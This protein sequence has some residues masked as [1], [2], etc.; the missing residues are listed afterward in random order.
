MR[1]S[2]DF[3]PTTTENAIKADS[4]KRTKPKI[5]ISLGRHSGPPGSIFGYAAC[6]RVLVLWIPMAILAVAWPWLEPLVSAQVITP[7]TGLHYYVLEN[8]NTGQVIQ[9]GKTGSAGGAFD[10]LFLGANTHYRIRVLQ[11]ANLLTGEI[12]FTTPE[13][14][15]RFKLPEIRVGTDLS[16]DSDGDGLSDYA[17]FVVGTDPHNPD[18]DGDGIS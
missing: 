16:P 6:R 8:L 10:R 7:S 4:M 2:S 15:A 9:R 14:G 18:T 13:N 12:E 1:C 3:G 5:A 11:A 17:E